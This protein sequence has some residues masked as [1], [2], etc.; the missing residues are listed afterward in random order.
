MKKSDLKTGMVVEYRN[1]FLRLVVDTKLVDETGA[2]QNDLLFFNDDLTDKGG[3][4]G[5]LDIVAVYNSFDKSKC[6]WRR[7][8]DHTLIEDEKVILRN[9]PKGFKYIARDEDNELYIYKTKPNKDNGVWLNNKGVYDFTTFNHIFQTIK[10]EDKE[11]YLISDL[12]GET[13]VKE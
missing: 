7:K 9:I 4:E 8:E 2:G 11:P 13:V 6:L 3:S 1:G 5:K 12:L 10:C